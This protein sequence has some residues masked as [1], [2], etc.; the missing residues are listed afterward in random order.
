MEWNG[1][2]WNGVLLEEVDDE[3]E[4]NYP[5][6]KSNLTIVELP[7]ECI[8]KIFSYLS[9]PEKFSL[10]DVCL[11]WREISENGWPDVKRLFIRSTYPRFTAAEIEI[12]FRRCGRF[13]KSMRIDLEDERTNYLHFIQKYCRNLKELEIDFVQINWRTIVTLYYVDYFSRVYETCRDLRS[14]KILSLKSN[15]TD[16]YV[17]NLRCEIVET[18]HLTVGAHG[19]HFSL[20]LS[21]FRNLRCLNLE[22]FIIEEN[23]LGGFDR[24]QHLEELYFS[25]CNV[26]V[27]YIES[28]RKFKKLEKLWMN[29][30][31]SEIRDDHLSM[32]VSHCKRLK[33]LN[34]DG[35][36][37]LT[38]RCFRDVSQLPI[39]EELHM[40][41]LSRV[42]D[43]SIANMKTLKT[44]S[45]PQCPGIGNDGLKRL[46]QGA[47]NLRFLSARRTSV[48]KNFLTDANEA[49]QS[50][51]SDVELFLDL[52]AEAYTWQVPTNFSSLLI[53]EGSTK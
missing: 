21:R 2:Y 27:S 6:W 29:G 14:I 16:A 36:R 41:N 10:E 8:L 45:C 12:I 22:R 3:G 11:R 31:I 44:L 33:I 47:P 53:L 43:D 50:R 38:D 46:I 34:V 25:F 52:G 42:T 20:N 26:H 17:M 28:I 5:D 23:S 30:T 9:I 40:M 15:F 13:L 35:L 37:G 48:N 32:I 51:Q 49:I 24:L 39:L 19:V 18:I 7:T 1:K 4:L